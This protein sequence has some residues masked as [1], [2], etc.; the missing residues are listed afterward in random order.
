MGDSRIVNTV[1]DHEVNI[2]MNTRKKLTKDDYVFE[3]RDTE[4]GKTS[5]LGKGA[6]GVVRLVHRKDD[7]SKK[8]AMKIVSI[9][10]LIMSPVD[11]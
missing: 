4:F 10:N 7:P 1:M 9:L 8:F 11:Q 6:F 5:E 3:E 2:S